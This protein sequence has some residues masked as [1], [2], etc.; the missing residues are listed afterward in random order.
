[1]HHALA[2]GAGDGG[3]EDERSNEIEEGGP[4]DGAERREDTSGNDG[5]DGIGS[6]AALEKS[7]AKGDAKTTMNRRVSWSSAGQAL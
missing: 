3:A 7:N 6:V 5:G 2:N 4:N 1:V